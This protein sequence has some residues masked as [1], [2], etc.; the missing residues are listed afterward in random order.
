MD[1]LS[2]VVA[3]INVLSAS[4]EATS[5]AEDRPRYESH[6]AS[7]ARLVALLVGD[8]PS[9]DV[10]QWFRQEDRAFGWG[11]LSGEAGQA[12]EEAFEGLK[13]QIDRD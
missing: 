4:A 9:D 3:Y 13:Q 5:R 10:Q 11:Y 7:A 12:A 8:A 2:A 6:L 1:S